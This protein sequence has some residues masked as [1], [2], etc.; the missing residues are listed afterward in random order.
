MSFVFVAPSSYTDQEEETHEKNS[1]YQDNVKLRKSDIKQE[2]DH[3]M[4]CDMQYSMDEQSEASTS[5][6]EA[7]EELT[8][9]DNEED[10]EIPLPVTVKRKRAHNEEDEKTKESESAMYT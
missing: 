6:S 8:S 3:N 10:G 9:Q 5:D 1:L 7:A 4:S 2:E